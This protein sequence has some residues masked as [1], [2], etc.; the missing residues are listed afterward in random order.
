MQEREIHI[1]TSLKITILGDAAVGKTTLI[2]AFM[3]GIT[4]DRKYKGTLGAEIALKKLRIHYQGKNVEVSVQLWDLAGQ[5]S[6]A[7][8]RQTFYLGSQGA[9]LVYD[10]GRPDTL[11]NLDIWLKDLFDVSPRK[12]PVALV[13]NKIDLREK[14][15]VMVPSN[16]GNQKATEISTISGFNTPFIE[17]SAIRSENA[18]KP[19]EELVSLIYRNIKRITR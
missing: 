8:I 19:F 14:G 13:G 10:V 16:M 4:T 1:K 7:N 12:I 5:P 15:M 3:E 17:A 11:N 9:I 6:F 18:D 2:R